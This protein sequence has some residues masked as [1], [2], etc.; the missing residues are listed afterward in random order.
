MPQ[1]FAANRPGEI[2]EEDKETGGDDSDKLKRQWEAFR[3][4]ALQ[5]YK[6]DDEEQHCISV[7]S[8]RALVKVKMYRKDSDDVE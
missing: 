3:R 6:K 7:P 5:K 4:L 2:A 1:R 8:L